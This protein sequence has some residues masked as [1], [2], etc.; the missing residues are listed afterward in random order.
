VQMAMIQ[1]VI[2]VDVCFRQALAKGMWWGAASIFRPCVASLNPTTD[3]DIA[4][5]KSFMCI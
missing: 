4:I 5:A 1:Y 3:L 2:S